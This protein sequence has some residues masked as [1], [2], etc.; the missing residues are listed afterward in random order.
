MRHFLLYSIHK[1]I[2]LAKLLSFITGNVKANISAN[3]REDMNKMRKEES[4]EEYT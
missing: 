1:L 4:I 3:E 2:V